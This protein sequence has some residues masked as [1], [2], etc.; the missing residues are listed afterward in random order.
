MKIL[1]IGGVAAGTKTAAKLKR[2]DR[3]AEVTLITKS[4][5]IS[6][7]GCGLPY[8]VG[9]MIE[10]RDE[11]IVNTPE[12]Y[13][14]LTG[15][16]VRT[17]RE[18]VK[19]DAEA[20]T[21]TASN[22]D[23]GEQEVYE[24]DRLVIAVGASP[25]VPPVEGLHL[26]GVFTMR[27]PDD[28][29][30]MRTYIEKQNVKKAVVVGGGF[31]GLEVAENLHAR[32]VSVTVIDF[33]SQIM[34]NVLDPELADWAKKK[35]AAAGVRV[36][37]STAAQAIEGEERV[38][39]IRTSAGTLACDLV[40]LSAGIRPNTGFL[41]DTGLAMVKGTIVVDEQM[42]TNLPDVYAAG[43]CAMVKN[44]LTGAPQWSP[45]GSTANLSGRTLAEGLMGA[46]KRYP[47]VLGT[48][49]AK[50][51]G[52]S[53]GRTGLTE[54]QAKDAGFDPVCA[55]AVTDDKA[56]Y[57]PGAA[58]FVTKVV[59]D[60]ATRR[61]LGVQVLG[62]GAVDK[63]VDIAAMGLNMGATLEDFENADFAYAPPFS[64]AIHPLVQAVYVLLNKLD[65]ALTSITPAEYLAGA[66]EGRRVLDVGLAPSIRGAQYIDLPKVNGPIEGIA[67]DEKLLLVCTK[68]KRAYFLQNRLRHFGYT[69]TLVLEGGVFVSDVKLKNV[70][71]AVTPA[72]EKAVKALGFLRDKTTPDCFNGRVITR[73]GKITAEESRV[74][75]E[76][77]EK[78][79]SGEVTMTSRLTLEIQ[80]VPFDHIEPMRAFL[81]ER[82]LETGGT[83]S[84]VRPVVSCKGTTC[85][86]GLIDT[87]ALS[88]EIHERFFHGYSDVKLPHKFKIAVGGC[89]NNCV[90]PDL[91]D[92]GV[93]G[94]RVPAV[95]Y[96]K[97]RGCKLCQVENG[98]PIKVT[99]MQD[100]KLVIDEA[101]CNHCGRCIA[102]CPFGALDA[103]MEGYR[104]YIG[105]RWGKK[106]AQGRP[107]D[108][109]FTDKEEV[110][111]VIE[112][113][114]LLFREQGVTGER[115]ADTVSRLGFENVQEQLLSN[116]LLAHKQENLS[117]QKHLQGGATC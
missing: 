73:N 49:V 29:E 45:M 39:A 1:I 61:L 97:C 54:R 106:V 81:A 30:T 23:S 93:I 75:A 55:V 117:A 35:L 69:D 44:R 83:G 114:I 15:V 74:I 101:A 34:P 99:R 6:Y 110:M 60:R 46:D 42:R 100:D 57:Y 2:L 112:K 27:T 10:T 67:Q 52:L 88:E 63:M 103:Q 77:A 53:C 72:E 41:A 108:K 58:Y 89:P 115:F 109:V 90:K 8:Y 70:A 13:A 32:G 11:L 12:K 98:C 85:Q 92:L 64:T 22:L 84:K 51:P 7:A 50:L 18:A 78:F 107:L 17:G 102:M 82:G 96:E 116:E 25:S 62:P 59:A 3:G 14:A 95:D 5:D 65:G 33:A 48:G 79:G 76:A 37:T 105:G 87:F 19:L 16:T 47:G 111:S 9:G 56:H 43:D 21:V 80:G 31:I 36:I 20:K 104:I 86:Y 26:G 40:V 91:N 24:Y 68:G 66:A 4:R 38:S 94:Q 113:S 28:A 71:A